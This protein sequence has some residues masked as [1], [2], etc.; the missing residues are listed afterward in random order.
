MSTNTLQSIT[1]RHT[2]C[3][4]ECIKLSASNSAHQ[5]QRIGKIR[6]EIVKKRSR[7]IMVKPEEYTSSFF[8]V[9]T[10]LTDKNKDTAY[11][12]ILIL[13]GLKQWRNNISERFQILSEVEMAHKCD[14]APLRKLNKMWYR[15]ENIL[16]DPILTLPKFLVSSWPYEVKNP[17]RTGEQSRNM[18]VSMADACQQGRSA[19]IIWRYQMTVLETMIQISKWFIYHKDILI[20]HIASPWVLPSSAFIS[21]LTHYIFDETGCWDELSSKKPE[22]DFCQEW[23]TYIWRFH[24]I[25]QIEHAVVSTSRLRCHGNTS[26]RG[27]TWSNVACTKPYAFKNATE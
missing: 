2:Q 9:W 3:Q 7:M 13:M 18:F 5:I 11:I 15:Q 4:I 20:H 25:L 24:I 6:V 8:Q 27:K 26:Q 14:S 12:L 22:S 19:K 21:M 17:R 16:I 10:Q 23:A 1:F